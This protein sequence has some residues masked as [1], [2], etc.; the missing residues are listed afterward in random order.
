MIF[1]HKY[2]GTDLHEIDLAYVLSQV[3]NVSDKINTLY[4]NGIVKF[5]DPVVWSITE[6]Y[7]AGTIVKD[8]ITTNFYISKQLVPAGIQLFNTDYW[9]SLGLMETADYSQEIARLDTRIDGVSAVANAAETAATSAG[10]AAASAQ[11]A[12]NTASQ[13]ATSASQT[14]NDAYNTANS[15][16]TAANNANQTAAAAQQTANSIASVANTALST[17]QAAGSDAAD[18]LDA[19]QTAQDTADGI[20][21]TASAAFIMAQ[22]ASNDADTAITTAQ[23]AKT[24][25]EGIASTANTALTTALSAAADAGAAMQ[26]AGGVADTAD[27]ALSTAQA[28]QTTANTVSGTATLALSTAQTASNNA[29]SAL[30]AAQA[31]QTEAAAKAPINHA[32][33][34]TTYGQGNASNYGHV[35]V[36]DSRN[37]DGAASSGVA[38]SSYA[39]S[40]VN[41]LATQA[42]NKIKRNAA[43]AGA[44]ITFQLESNVN[45]AIIAGK[46]SANA[47]VYMFDRYTDTAVT[48]YQTGTAPTISFDRSTWTISVT[49]NTTGNLP[50]ICINY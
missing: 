44:T 42:D 40:L 45:I 3:K 19:A 7:T 38:A 26:V 41:A 39:L 6:Q 43:A 46:R 18:A 32:S 14:A 50:V 5:A 21:D 11:A 37:N 17:A 15:A 23:D 25:A 47:F 9:Q 4:E 28:A 30:S 33:A 1:D 27:Q 29:S 20:A 48:I 13:T 10:A 2:P 16:Q 22:A 8:S 34:Q 36:S 35:K 49:N 31:A 24:T 12:A